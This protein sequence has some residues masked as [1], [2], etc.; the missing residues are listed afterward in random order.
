MT[1][2]EL[3]RQIEPFALKTLLASREENLADLPFLTRGAARLAYGVVTGPLLTRIVRLLTEVTVR[4]ARRALAD[5]VAPAEA[6]LAALPVSPEKKA[7]A[8]DYIELLKAP[9]ALF[10]PHVRESVG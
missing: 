3:A 4:F 8:L 6:F 9:D 10:S 5:Y 2:A 1:P 7:T